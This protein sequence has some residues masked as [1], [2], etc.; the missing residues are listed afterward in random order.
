MMRGGFVLKLPGLSL[1]ALF[2]VTS[3]AFSQSNPPPTTSAP[4]AVALVSQALAKLTAAIQIN[5]I[6][7]TGA[8]TRTAGLDVE[9]G[10]ISLKALGTEEARLDL[11]VADGT[12]S[13]I[14]NLNSNSAPQ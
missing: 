2:L 9:S 14:R 11:S 6:T 10:S 8:G 1:A 4:Q 7:L 12:R 5:D 13:E 3:S